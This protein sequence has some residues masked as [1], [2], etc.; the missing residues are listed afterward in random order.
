MAPEGGFGPAGSA[1]TPASG[2]TERMQLL[3]FATDAE[4][5]QALRKGLT[6]ILGA[7]LEIRRCNLDMAIAV[8]K[9]IPSPRQL[10][11]DVGGHAQPLAALE[12]LAQVL[13]PDVKVLVIGD[14]PDVD[15]YRKVTRGLGA[16][17][18]LY[19]PLTPTVVA[20]HFGPHLNERPAGRSTIRGGRVIALT[21]A[22]GGVG[23]S[24]LAANLAWLLA[25]QASRHAALLDADLL[26]GTGGLLLAATPGPGLRAALEKPERMDSLLVERATTAVTDRLHLLA[27]E[28]GMTKR[29][30][31]AAGAAEQLLNLLERRFNYIVVDV[32]RD[33][34]AL[35]ADLLKLA[36]QRVVVI[37]PS[38]AA[39]RDGLRLLHSQG[40]IAEARR[41][42]LVVN[43][44]GR[45]GG[46]SANELEEAMRQTPDLSIPDLPKVL[47][48]AATLGEVAAAKPGPFRT[49][50][51]AL[52]AET[53]AVAQEAKPKRSFFARLGRK[54]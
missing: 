29:P 34:S 32:P 1:E 7:P 52:A 45:P 33:G 15:F 21:G 42:L 26:T 23:T 39:V 18:Y 5:E 25:S 20:E 3:S 51:Q 30:E 36:H 54:R 27:G 24:T 43:R 12:E 16:V 4:T 48:Q 6:D 2:R 53:A 35:S 8:L 38:L 37:E 10:I 47:G 41:P 17:D 31:Y 50:M 11:V 40:G 14:R 49:A 13:E 22:R 28:E 44:S 9:R 19:R 46:L